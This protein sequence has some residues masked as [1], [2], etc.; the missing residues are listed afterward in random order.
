MP[1]LFVPKEIVPGE[2][3]VAAVP[4]TVK[5]LIKAG[6]TVAV[7]AGAGAGCSISDQSYRDAGATVGTDLPGLYQSADAV[8]KVHAPRQHDALGKHEVDLLKPGTL[9]LSFLFPMNNLELVERLRERRITAFAMDQI[10]RITR[11]Q[12][13]DA[14]SSQANLAGYK[15]VILGAD[16]LGK[17]FPMLMTAA[18]TVPPARVVILGAGVAGL[19]AIATAKRLGAVVEVSDV[20]PAVKEQVQSLGGKFIEVETTSDMET[21]GGYAKEASEE[22][23]AKQRAVVDQHIMNADVVIGTAQVPGR[24]APKL[25]TAETVQKMKPGAVIVDLAAENGGNCALTEPGQVVT[26]YGVT[27]VGILNVPS[28][29]PVNASEVYSRNILNVLTLFTNKEKQ[30]NLDFGDEIVAGSVIVHAGE[31]KKAELADALG[32]KTH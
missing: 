8:A 11:A 4:E 9:L 31:V 28:L 20:R 17:I 15:A 22:F 30:L 26:K 32:V 21:K 23:L 18:G 2:T 7:E 1:T 25:I 10:P 16:H 6:W 29:L 27:L 19:Q 13:M 3:R 14:L 5:K 24:P 12:S